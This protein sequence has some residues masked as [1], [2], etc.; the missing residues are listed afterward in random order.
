MADAGRRVLEPLGY[1]SGLPLY[2]LGIRIAALGGG[3]ARLLN[4]GLNDSWH[5]LREGI[6]PEGDYLWIH[7]ASLGE[8]EQGRTLIERLKTDQP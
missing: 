4:G 8:F 1:G 2:R 6:A 7:C 5:I 3:K